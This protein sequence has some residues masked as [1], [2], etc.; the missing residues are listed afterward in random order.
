M[1]S[2]IYTV[3]AEVKYR[4][5]CALRRHKPANRGVPGVAA[6]SRLDRLR[7][8]LDALDWTK[9]W[10]LVAE[11]VSDRESAGLSERRELK[12]KLRVGGIWEKARL[13]TC[14]E[15]HEPREQCGEEG[16]EGRQTRAGYVARGVRRSCPVLKEQR[17]VC[18]CVR[19][20]GV[21]LLCVAFCV[22]F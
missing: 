3:A 5:S 1:S 4:C 20:C 18:V 10:A 6:W 17:C 2:H 19:L 8:G 22:F 7:W 11:T 14:E 16:G 12:T 13:T 15:T 9:A 21:R